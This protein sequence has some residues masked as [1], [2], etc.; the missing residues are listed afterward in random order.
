MRDKIESFVFRIA[1]LLSKRAKNFHYLNT[2]L[3]F[4]F[5]YISINKQN[6]FLL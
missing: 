2:Y 6:F 1:D 3:T 5:I 4:V